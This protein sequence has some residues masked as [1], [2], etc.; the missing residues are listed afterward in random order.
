MDVVHEVVVVIAGGWRA[1]EQGLVEGVHEHGF[2]TADGAVDVDAAVLL[3][4]RRSG[5]ADG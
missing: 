1:W 5:Q 4:G 2:A 3:G